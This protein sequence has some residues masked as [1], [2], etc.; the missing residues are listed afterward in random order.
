ML[1]LCVNMTFLLFWSVHWVN[2]SSS[3]ERVPDMSCK[4]P[5]LCPE[6]FP[7]MT[8]VRIF[9]SFGKLSTGYWKV[10]GRIDFNILISNFW[11]PGEGFQ[12]FRPQIRLQHAKISML[13]SFEVIWLQSKG[14]PK[15]CP[16]A[17]QYPDFSWKKHRKTQKPKKNIPG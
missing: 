12:G 5:A 9:D 10:T 13:T 17:F 4:S 3:L 14:F 8:Q 11:P 15:F 6:R 16:V 7:D 2:S 1:S